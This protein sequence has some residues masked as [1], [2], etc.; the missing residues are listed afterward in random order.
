MRRTI[1]ASSGHD[2]SLAGGGNAVLEPTHDSVAEADTAACLPKLDSATES[3]SGLLRQLLQEQG[4]HR[5][6]EPDVQMRD[7]AFS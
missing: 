2:L 6:L 5:S 1:A 4:V 3:A 7:V